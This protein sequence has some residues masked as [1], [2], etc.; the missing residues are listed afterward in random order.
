[1]KAMGDEVVWKNFRFK[2]TMPA[3]TNTFHDRVT[4][5]F[6]KAKELPATAVTIVDFLSTGKYP[7]SST[8][9]NMTKTAGFLD[10]RRVVPTII[11]MPLNLTISAAGHMEL[12]FQTSVD[13]TTNHPYKVAANWFV[14]LLGYKSRFYGAFDI[15]I[16]IKPKLSVAAKVQL[17]LDD[18]QFKPKLV[19]FANSSTGFNQNVYLRMKHGNTN[20]NISITEMP[21][22]ETLLLN[23]R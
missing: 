9:L 11:G 7:I 14:T 22:S 1:M 2:H 3:K 16:N 6:E 20:T 8:K 21:E 17:V 18:Y 19:F 5:F 4:Q 12:D 15:H 23:A 10:V 13:F